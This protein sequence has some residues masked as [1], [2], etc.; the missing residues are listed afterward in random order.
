[1]VI[2][3]FKEQQCKELPSIFSYLWYVYSEFYSQCKEKVRSRIATRFVTCFI[4]LMNSAKYN[5]MI[6]RASI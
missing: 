5:I 4:A 3:Y 6:R 2:Q 1:M